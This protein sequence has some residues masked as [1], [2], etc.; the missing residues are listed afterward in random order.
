MKNLTEVRLED[1]LGMESS[2]SWR[3]SICCTRSMVRQLVVFGMGANELHVDILHAV[4]NCHNQPVVVPLD[5][6]YD[7]V[8]GKDAGVRILN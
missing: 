1:A 5:V 4:G 2:A 3:R 7:A 8:V 6:E